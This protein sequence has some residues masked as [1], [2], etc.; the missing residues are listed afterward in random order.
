MI[1]NKVILHLS[2]EFIYFND[3]YCKYSCF[4][5][6][7]HHKIRKICYFLSKSIFVRLIYKISIISSLIILIME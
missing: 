3:V 5:F 6:T 7:Y 1:K 2:I 4:Y